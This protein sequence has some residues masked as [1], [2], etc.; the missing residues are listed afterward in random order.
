MK[1]KKYIIASVSIFIIVSFIFIR[2]YQH[3]KNNPL[4]TVLDVKNATRSN[5]QKFLDSSGMNTENNNFHGLSVTNFTVQWKSNDDNSS[6]HVAIIHVSKSPLDYVLS[7]IGSYCGISSW[8]R[9]IDDYNNDIHSGNGK[10]SNCDVLYG[11]GGDY[12]EITYSPPGE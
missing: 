1:S 10:G 9:S 12:W 4:E 7:K 6:M 8:N 11:N 2:H 3:I 5:L